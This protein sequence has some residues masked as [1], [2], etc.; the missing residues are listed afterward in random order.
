MIAD[1]KGIVQI[2]GSGHL[3]G[4]G[5]ITLASTIDSHSERPLLSTP[6]LLHADVVITSPKGQVNV[7]ISPGPIGVNPFAQPVRLQ[8]SVQGG[9]GA[10]R[11][12][13]GTGMVDLTLFQPIPTTLGQ[14][15]EM[16]NQL[17]TQ[18]IRFTLYFHPGHPGKWGDFSGLWYKVI[19]T[20][21]QTYGKHH[22]HP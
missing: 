2:T 8:Y 13:T 19:Q 4:L 10:F 3:S 22:S 7:R 14:L 6:W 18:G 11:N 1:H 9:T 16:G 5:P 12:A 15:K 17:E 21:V 20:A